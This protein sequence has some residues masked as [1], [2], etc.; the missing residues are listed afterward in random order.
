MENCTNPSEEFLDEK[1]LEDLLHCT[2]WTIFRLRRRPEFPQ[3]IRV[4]GRLL[5]LTAEIRNFIQA[6]RS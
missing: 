1:Q 2:R 6:Q 4:G 3:P 5:W